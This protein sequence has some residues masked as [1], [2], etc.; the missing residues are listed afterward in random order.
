MTAKY[1]LNIATRNWLADLFG[2]DDLPLHGDYVLIVHHSMGFK[3]CERIAALPARKV[4]VYH[5]ITPSEF[6]G[7]FP[8]IFRMR[9]SAAGS[10]RCFDHMWRPLS[11]TAN[12]MRWSCVQMATMHP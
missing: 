2:I 9:N 1:L 10:C 11:P 5:N 3:A 12:S 4:L 8:E 7:D 6:L